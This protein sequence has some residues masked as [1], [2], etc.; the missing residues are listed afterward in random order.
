MDKKYTL[1]VGASE[2]SMRYSNMA[3]KLLTDFE[4]SV[5]AYGLRKGMIN[6]VEINTEWPKTENFNT[7]T[8]YIGPQNQTVYYD[9]IIALNPQRVIF[10]PGTEND[11]LAEKLREK[12]VEVVENCTLVMLNTGVF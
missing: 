3:V 2:K 4:H 6:D 5:Y 10:N 8:M 11:E 12:G 7:I 1:V 9:K